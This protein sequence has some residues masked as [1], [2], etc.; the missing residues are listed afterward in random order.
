MKAIA[1]ELAELED[2]SAGPEASTRTTPASR[3]G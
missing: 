2:V 3:K 1:A